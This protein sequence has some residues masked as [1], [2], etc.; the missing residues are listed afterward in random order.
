MIETME[1]Y[2]PTA[3]TAIPDHD[4]A[5][6]AI[7]ERDGRWDGRLVYAVTSTGIY[8]RPSCPSRRPLRRNVRLFAAP[9]DAEREGFRACRRCRPDDRPRAA[10]AVARAR[11]LL[12]DAVARGAEGPVTLDR[13]AAEVGMSPYH[14]QRVF[15]REVGLSPSAY[16]RHARG[17]RLK[18]RLR[19]GDTVTRA[20]FDAGFASG[21]R[22]YDAARDQ[23]GMTP[24]AYLRHA[25]GERLKRRLRDGDTVTQA[26]FD[27][28][29]ASGSRAY[30][31]ARDQ[32]GMTPATYRRGGRGARVRVRVVP[33]SLGQLLVAATERGVC[34]VTLGDDPAALERELAAEL[35]QAEIVRADDDAELARWVDAVVARA[36]AAPTA[37]DVPLD[38]RATAFQRRVWDALRRIPAGETRS[39]AAIAA[40][41][42]APNAVRAV[43][44][45]CATNPTALVVPC[46]RVVRTDGALAGYRWGVERKRELLE[47][48]R[49]ERDQER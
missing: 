35:P 9:A 45:A 47:R 32:L 2:E 39:Y 49:R 27:A 21:S 31:A 8:C 19:D 38:V 22:A 42:G 41:L 7:A 3:A 23:L 43:A 17:E 12:D 24:A 40:E 5:W 28:G 33:T 30:D 36:E 14:L 46:H 4:E 11:A 48:E 10:H 44:R 1:T 25:R 37:A 18:R 15:A 6:Q 26:A 16:L 13:L 34:A 20:A 29:F